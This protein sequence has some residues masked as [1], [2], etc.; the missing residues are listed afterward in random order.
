MTR[1][2]IILSVLFLAIVALG[3]TSCYKDREEL[4]YSPDC[5]NPTKIAGPNFTNVKNI[6]I[7][8]CSDCHLNGNNQGGY[9][10]DTDCE[11]VN[12]WN[13]IFGDCVNY[14]PHQMP[15]LQPL[16]DSDKSKITNWV[17]AGHKFTD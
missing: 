4:L 12:N 10:F 6:V 3:I 13:L 16:S 14:S 1:K 9:S 17:N 11:I 2:K 15:T 8:N 5:S 7:D